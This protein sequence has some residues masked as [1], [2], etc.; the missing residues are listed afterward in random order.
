[1]CIC[2]YAHTYIYVPHTSGAQLNKEINSL[3]RKGDSKF[4]LKES[5]M[6]LNI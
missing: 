2:V 4:H 5:I 1:M 3:Y 6:G